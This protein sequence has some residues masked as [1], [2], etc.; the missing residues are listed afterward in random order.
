MFA[1]I[2]LLALC[3]IVAAIPVSAQNGGEGVLQKTSF[4]G[5]SGFNHVNS[6]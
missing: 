6:V 2:L 4:T 1:R 3:T 5:L